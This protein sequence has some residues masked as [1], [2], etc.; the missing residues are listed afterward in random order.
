VLPANARLPSELQHRRFVAVPLTAD[1]A[2]LDYSAYMSS[3]EV[4]RVHSDGRWPV[5]DFSFAS[6]LEQVQQHW[7]DHQARRAF[8]F[9][10]LTPSRDESLGCLYLNPLSEFLSRAGASS[11]TVDALPAASAMV[12]FWLRQDQQDSGLA[13]AVVGAVGEWLRHDWPL[14]WYLF[15]VLPGERSSCAA[16]DE[17]ALQRIRLALPGEPRPY[18]WYQPA[19]SELLASTEGLFTIQGVVAI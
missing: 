16:L 13:E 7:S 6:D 8:A 14:D 15:R 19:P 5:N 18:R 10:L 1:V 9:T 2:A 12:T 11:Q 3:A 4:I 17:S